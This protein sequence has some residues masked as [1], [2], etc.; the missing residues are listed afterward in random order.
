[1]SRRKEEHHTRRGWK[2]PKCD[3]IASRKYDLKK[4]LMAKHEMTGEE[5]LVWQGK[6]LEAWEQVSVLRY[7]AD[8]PDRYSRELPGG[9]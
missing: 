2:C 7:V 4:H 6:A 1:M 3:H 5:A 8:E 9:K